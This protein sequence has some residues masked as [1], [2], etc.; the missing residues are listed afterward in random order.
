MSPKKQVMESAS[1]SLLTIQLPGL[2]DSTSSNYLQLVSLKEIRRTLS[3]LIN[4][5][6]DIKESLT[7][8]R[9]QTLSKTVV[10]LSETTLEQIGSALEQIQ[11]Y[12]ERIN[13]L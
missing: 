10:G 13:T 3:S 8:L 2:D 7:D 5:A 6:N 4:S 9:N 12:L 1:N 11:S